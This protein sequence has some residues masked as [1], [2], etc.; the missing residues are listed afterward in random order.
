[1]EVSGIPTG[2]WSRC[3]V[4]RLVDGQIDMVCCQVPGVELDVVLVDC[5]G[6]RPFLDEYDPRCPHKS[7]EPNPK[8]QPAI[9]L[10]WRLVEK[11]DFAT[12]HLPQPPRDRGFFRTIQ[13]GSKHPGLIYLTTRG[14]SE[15]LNESLVKA[16]VC[17]L[18]NR[19]DRNNVRKYARK[20]KQ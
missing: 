7:R 8:A 10:L 18:P 6:P 20:G 13:P 12:L 4:M 19:I 3:R 14:K 15:S 9:D 5:V 17:R 16:G 11:A 2:I 1:M